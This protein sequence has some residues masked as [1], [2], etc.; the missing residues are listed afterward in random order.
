MSRTFD[1]IVNYECKICNKKVKNLLGLSSHLKVHSLSNIEYFY[2]YDKEKINI[3]ICKNCGTER[4]YD[5]L[6][7]RRFSLTCSKKCDYSYRMKVLKNKYGDDYYIKL[8]SNAIKYRSP[9]AFSVFQ[10]KYWTNRGLSEEEAVK[11]ISEINRKNSPRC[12]EHYL[13]FNMSEDEISKAISFNQKYNSP[14]TI[15]YWVMRRFS[16]EEAVSAVHDFQNLCSI[17]KF[18]SRYGV[19]EGNLRY[20]EHI[21]KLK[22]K[23]CFTVQGWINNGLSYNEAVNKIKEIQ[24][25]AHTSIYYLRK[26]ERS[27][28]KILDFLSIEYEYQK[29]F[30]LEEDYFLD[31]S[32]L[33]FDY[34]LSKFN[35]DIEMDGGHWHNSEIDVK[36]DDYLKNK[37]IFVLRIIQDS[38]DKLRFEEKINFIKEKLCELKK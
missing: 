26:F 28:Q 1:E 38:W 5:N 21:N 12:R 3:L 6:F 2:K 27:L 11:K 19:I 15:E 24:K 29:V 32:M 14:R 37:G 31:K 30:K 36:R 13:N 9:G 35:L 34:Y 16:Y 20:G 8:S 22:N 4:S 23:N 7:N 10:K 17:E 33:I 25:K 18:V